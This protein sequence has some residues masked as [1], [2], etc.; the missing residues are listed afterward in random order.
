LPRWVIKII[1]KIRRDFIWGNTSSRRKMVH[2]INWQIVSSPK[3]WV[4]LEIK[5]VEL[6]N[7][8]L[9]IRWWWRAHKESGSL[10][11]TVFV[12]MHLSGVHNNGPPF[13]RRTRSFF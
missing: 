6:H 1:D 7:K 4:G 13:W 12:S 9:M 8:A 5:N 3:K 2:L 10:L 11:T